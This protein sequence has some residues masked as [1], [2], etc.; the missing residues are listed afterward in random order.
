VDAPTIREVIRMAREALPEAIVGATLNQYVAEQ[1]GVLRNLL[2]KLA[3]GASYVQTQP[4]F[5]PGPLERYATVIEREHPET[6]LVAMVMPLL[7]LEAAMRIEKRLGIGLP[8]D[9]R[10][11][12][13]GGDQE[14][15]WGYFGQTV[16]SLAK[17]PLVDG[18]AV[19]TFEM[20]A[21]EGM[22][23]RIA[24]ALRACGAV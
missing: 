20:D 1:A 12:L 15:A 17:S 19:M 18:V 16:R 11:V 9:L 14:A 6:K 7:S 23:E 24:S 22:G 2:P 4:V 21:P 13:A 10:D 8:V 5:E 3:A